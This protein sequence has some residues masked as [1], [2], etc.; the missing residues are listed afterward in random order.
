MEAPLG[1]MILI[2][3]LASF[4]GVIALCA[5]IYGCIKYLTK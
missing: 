5:I 2:Q 1:Y 4:I 3:T